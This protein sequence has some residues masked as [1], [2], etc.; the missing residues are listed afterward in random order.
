[1]KDLQE[2][3]ISQERVKEL[4]CPMGEDFGRNAPSEI[5]LSVA[6]QLLKVRDHYIDPIR[7][8]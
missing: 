7:K 5:A 4:H 3:G 8:A 1:V 2:K 6:A